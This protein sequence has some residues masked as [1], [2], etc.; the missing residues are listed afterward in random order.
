MA[1]SIRF[2]ALGWNTEEERVLLEKMINEDCSEEDIRKEI[3]RIHTEFCNRPISDYSIEDFMRDLKK[4][5]ELDLK[6]ENLED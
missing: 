4:D 6:D 1:A 3:D 2:I 5:I